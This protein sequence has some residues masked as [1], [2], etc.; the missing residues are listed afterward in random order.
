MFT[1]SIVLQPVPTNIDADTAVLK[2]SPDSAERGPTSDLVTVSLKFTPSGSDVVYHSTTDTATVGVLFAPG[3][4]SDAF[5]ADFASLSLKLI[6]SASEQFLHNE[7]YGTVP[8]KLSV[9]AI[10]DFAPGD[11]GTLLTKLSPSG[12]EAAHVFTDAG[13]LLFHLTE[14]YI[15]HYCVF[16]S[17]FEGYSFNKW[18]ATFAQRWI[19]D[20]K[21]RWVGTLVEGGEPNPC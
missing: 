21:N 14:Q 12:L 13:T 17:N 16:S 9:S 3:A 18:T 2:L 4:I 15:E 6:P 10:V 5:S 7:E 8:L 11:F 19:G 20:A 1:Y